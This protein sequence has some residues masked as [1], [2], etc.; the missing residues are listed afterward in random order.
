MV[1]TVVEGMANFAVVLV[2]VI[3]GPAGGGGFTASTTTRLVSTVRLGAG[4]ATGAGLG[5]DVSV[6]RPD[7]PLDAAGCRRLAFGCRVFE[8]VAELVGSGTLT[9]ALCG[10]A[11]VAGSRL[12]GAAVT[13][14]PEL[15]AL[16]APPVLD[17]FP[18]LVARIS[19]AD[20]SDVDG[21]LCGRKDDRADPDLEA[22]GPDTAAAWE[23]VVPRGD[24]DFP[25]EESDEE[26]DDG[27][28]PE[29]VGDA[30]ASPADATRPTPIPKATTSAPTPLIY[31]AS[32]IIIASPIHDDEAKAT[33]SVFAAKGKPDYPL[34]SALLAG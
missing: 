3:V 10:V 19:G 22:D 14:L 32:P 21:A 16:R 33:P 27:E 34:K 23:P 17:A 11:G 29:F 18:G 9:P 31:R 4:S 1:A 8:S 12:S 2:A 5:S 20:D 13:P 6:S 26:S 24:E 30:E 7:I 25:A 28:G 15:W